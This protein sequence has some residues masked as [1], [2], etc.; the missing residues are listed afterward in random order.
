MPV[1]FEGEILAVQVKSKKIKVKDGDTTFEE[2]QRIGRITIEFDA[3]SVDVTGIADLTNGK[4][5]TL[6]F[7]GTQRSFMTSIDRATGEI[8]N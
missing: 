5:I 8:K 4:S 6:S 7:A 3:D 1:N 2:I